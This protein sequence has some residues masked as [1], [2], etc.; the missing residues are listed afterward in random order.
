MS[1]PKLCFVEVTEVTVKAAFGSPSVLY[2]NILLNVFQILECVKDIK[3]NKK[4][5]NANN[6]IPCIFLFV[7]LILINSG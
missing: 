6:D 3:K 2:F 4:P 5:P 7:N 1:L